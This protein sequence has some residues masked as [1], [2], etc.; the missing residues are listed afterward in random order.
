ML[1]K[2][3]PMVDSFCDDWKVIRKQIR[4]TNIYICKNIICKIYCVFK[5]FPWIS[6]VDY[7]KM[8]FQLIVLQATAKLT[9]F[10]TFWLKVSRIG[11]VKQTCCTTY[12]SISLFFDRM[13]S[14]H[15]L[16]ISVTKTTKQLAYYFHFCHEDNH[17]TILKLM[18]D[19]I[20]TLPYL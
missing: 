16:N 17:K 6:W 8:M 15:W 2:N 5:Y 14:N 9:V 3:Y 18:S 12:T 10:R 13:F 11:W 20:P 1:K 19:A 4:K 7:G